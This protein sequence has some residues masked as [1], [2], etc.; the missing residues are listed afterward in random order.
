MKIVLKNIDINKI[1]EM[2]DR[3]LVGKLVEVE[4]AQGDIVEI[5]VE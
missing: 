2:V 1:L 4:S 5:V 3:G